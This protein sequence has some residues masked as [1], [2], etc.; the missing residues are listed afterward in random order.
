MQFRTTRK[1]LMI[2]I[3]TLAAMFA[4]SSLAGAQTKTAAKSTG[5]PSNDS[6]LKLPAG[7]CATIFAENIGH[8]R[9][10]VVAPNGTVYVNTWSGAYYGNKPSHEGGFLVALQDKAGKGKADV[11]ERFGETEA[12]GGKGGSGIGIYNGAIYAEINDRIVKYA[13]PSDGVVPTGS[14]ETVVSGLPLGGDHPMHPFLIDSKGAIYVDVASAS[15]SCQE[16]NRTLH[17]PGVQ[18]CTEL[19]TR[20]G[21]WLYDANK[22]GQTFSPSD[23]YATGIRNGEGFAIDGEGNLYVTQHGRDQLHTNWPEI[24]K[25]P[26]QEATLPAEELMLLKKDGDYGWPFCYYDPT[27]QK[28][29]LAP[30]YGGDGKKVGL[31]ADKTPPAAAFAAHWGPDGATY[32]DQK[33]FPARYQK[34]IFIAFHGSWNRAPYAQGGYNI[35]FQPLASGKSSGQCEIFADGFAGAVKSPDKAQYR[36]TGLAVGPDGALYVSDDQGGRIYRITYQAGAN[37]AAPK[38]TACPSAAAPAGAVVKA[39]ANSADS[40][41]ADAGTA[42]PPGVTKATI[43]L[44]KRVYQG[45]VGGAGCTGCHG[46]VGKGSTLGPDLTTKKFA[47]SDGSFDGLQKTIKEGVTKPKNYRSPMPPMGGVNLTA[48]QLKAVTAYVWSLS[49]K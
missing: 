30:E 45:E 31:C 38:F 2:L 41:N 46:E 28:L 34:G 44:G 5:C 7:F 12:S 42:T 35:V 4:S 21:I 17:S 10:L 6:G 18:P 3:V 37:A 27:V 49:H 22:T 36:P 14:P 23:R 43:A 48:P 9:H 29:V 8:P 24:I 26:T 47:W 39:A 25:D 1:T 20:G 16:K 32:Y 19:E 40:A 11:N 33:E 15:N 13:M